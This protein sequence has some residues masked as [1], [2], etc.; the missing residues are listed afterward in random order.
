MNGN[1]DNYDNNQLNRNTEKSGNGDEKRIRNEER[2][3]G[4]TLIIGKRSNIEV[5]V[6]IIIRIR[7]GVGF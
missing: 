7:V 4:K 6:G 1:R 3:R 2:G 5:G